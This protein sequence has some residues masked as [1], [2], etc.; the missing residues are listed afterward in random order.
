MVW[1]RFYTLKIW[2]FKLII[3]VYS[4]PISA[5]FDVYV[6]IH[7]EKNP[8]LCILELL[9]L[10]NMNYNP[11]HQEQEY[12]GSVKFTR[13]FVLLEQVNF[14]II[15]QPFYNQEVKYCSCAQ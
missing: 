5:Y 4:F 1:C 14:D 10:S 13:S 7:E 12:A 9:W 6:I 8:V 11:D 3:Y 15:V 2:S